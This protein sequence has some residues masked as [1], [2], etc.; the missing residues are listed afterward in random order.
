MWRLRWR[1]NH[2]FLVLGKRKG[3]ERSIFLV[4]PLHWFV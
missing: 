3:C 2:G 4:D 1:T